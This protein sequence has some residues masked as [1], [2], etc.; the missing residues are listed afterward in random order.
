MLV[1]R[2]CLGYPV[3]LADWA[4]ESLFHPRL[5]P[6]RGENLNSTNHPSLYVCYVL[7]S[8]RQCVLLV[9]SLLA[10]QR[11]YRLQ[12]QALRAG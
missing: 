5:F 2:S 4:S 7:A 1:P 11:R 8:A 12:L 10:L 3:G 6:L 9:L